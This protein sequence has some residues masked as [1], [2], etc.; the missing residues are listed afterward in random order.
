[1]EKFL[2]NRKKLALSFCANMGNPKALILVIKE[3]I[4]EKPN[5]E[6]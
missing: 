5:M 3:K 2:K 4:P 1:M 6:I